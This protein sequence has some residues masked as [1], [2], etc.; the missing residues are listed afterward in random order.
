MVAQHLPLTLKAGQQGGLEP[1]LAF[2]RG[3]SVLLLFPQ[4]SL[5][6]EPP[7]LTLTALTAFL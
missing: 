1:L 3:L 2:F 5:N 4:D 6:D 7:A